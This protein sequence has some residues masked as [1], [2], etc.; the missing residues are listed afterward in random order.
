MINKN[1]NRSGAIFKAGIIKCFSFLK[2]TKS[3]DDLHVKGIPLKNNKGFLLP[4]SEL[5]ATDESLI[6]DMS[7][8][9][10]DSSYAFPTQFPVTEEGTKKWLRSQVLDNP[11]KMLFLL[12]D[13]FG[14]RIGHLG[15]ANCLNDVGEMEIDNVVRGV[16]KVSPGIMTNAMQ[17][18]LDWADEKLLP[19]RINLL[20]LDDNN[21]AITFYEKLGFKFEEKIP[22]HKKEKGDRIEYVRLNKDDKVATDKYFIKMLYSSNRVIDTTEI[23]LTAGPSISSL[24]SS[25]VFDAVRNGWNSQWNNYIKQFEEKF[26]EYLGVKYSLTTSCCTGALHLSLISLDIGPG[27]EVIVPDTTWVA[28]AQV[29]N[30][31]GATPIFADIQQDSWCLD[32]DSFEAKITKRTKAVIPVHLYG[33]PAEMD[34]IMEIAQKHNLYVV[35]DAA[36]SIGAEFKGQKTGTFGDFAAFSFQGA[37]LAVTGEGGMIVTNNKKLYEKMHAIWDQGR[38]PGTFWIGEVGWKYKMSN[39][40]AAIGLGQ[41]ERIDELVEA[42]RRIFSWYS[43]GLELVKQVRLNH[44]MPWARSIYWMVSIYLD[45]DTGIS[46]DELMLQLKERNIDTR[47]VFPAISQYP[48]WPKKQDPQPIASRIG[49]QAINLPSGVCLKKEQV[50]YVCKSICEILNNKK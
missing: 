30:Y 3:L 40:Q 45:E 7:K 49:N 28:S 27:D 25:Y 21:K 42:K 8:W 24:E 14:N 18:L 12:V 38:I 9:R 13:N 37:K 48:I 1:N 4:I 41:L 6:K 50:E 16:N 5:H 26:A 32:P 44:E 33:H 31:V 34:R 43:E 36:P 35:E 39:I 19:R 2:N 15:Y 20:V 11:S 29:V 10:S 22:L 47:P 17:V 46:R 23:I